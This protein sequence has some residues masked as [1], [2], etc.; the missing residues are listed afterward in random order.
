MNKYYGVNIMKMNMMILVL[1][2]SVALA[3]VSGQTDEELS[4]IQR[5]VA[6]DATRAQG[7]PA[8]GD[9]IVLVHRN[10]IHWEAMFDDSREYESYME[11]LAIEKASVARLGYV[12]ENN[13][14]ASRMLHFKEGYQF[15][16]RNGTLKENELRKKISN[17]R[18]A[19]IFKGVPSSVA[20]E[21]LGYSEWLG[22]TKAGWP[23]IQEYF[24]NPELGSCIYAENNLKYTCA[25]I[26]LIEEEMTYGVNGKYTDFEIRGSRKSGFVY[27][28]YWYDNR[29]FRQL[30]CA[31]PKYSIHHIGK[32]TKAAD[33][34]DRAL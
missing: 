9:G 24:V 31:W 20:T 15:S 11:E 5:A 14:L 32:V 29:Y 16:S 30:D 23:G 18:M 2:S 13:E 28:V 17:I 25:S 12:E 19:Y 6:A 33:V 3:S 27:S 1:S 7:L 22:Q 8:P 26:Q 34:I 21:V 4:A 10:D